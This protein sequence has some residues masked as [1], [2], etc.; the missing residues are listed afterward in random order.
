MTSASDETNGEGSG[1]RTGVHGGSD[2]LLLSCSLSTMDQQLS[3][4]LANM[5]VN[6]R[7]TSSSASGSSSRRGASS[8]GQRTVESLGRTIVGDVKGEMKARK[9]RRR[10]HKTTCAQCGKKAE[11]GVK[12]QMCSRCK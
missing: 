8:S 4:A 9:K 5:G 2:L 6:D 12:L 7:R 11:T 1:E 3:S 10:D